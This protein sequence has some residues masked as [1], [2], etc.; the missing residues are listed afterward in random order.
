MNFN[1]T[2]KEV[3]STLDTFMVIK[4][5]CPFCIRAADMLRQQEISFKEFDFKKY[6]QLN[7]DITEA[8]DHMTYPKIYLNKEW[9]GGCSDLYEYFKKKNIM[10]SRKAEL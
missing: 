8:T 2:L 10:K 3:L 6:E 7:K 5:G 1:V 9:V 4:E